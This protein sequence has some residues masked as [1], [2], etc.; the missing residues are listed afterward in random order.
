LTIFERF[1]PRSGILSVTNP[2]RFFV[3]IS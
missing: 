3:T 1:S 2:L